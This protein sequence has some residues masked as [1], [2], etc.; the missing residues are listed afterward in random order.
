M[1][2]DMEKLLRCLEYLRKT[3][4]LVFSIKGDDYLNLMTYIDASYT[5]RI[6]TESHMVY[7]LKKQT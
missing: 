1:L 2:Q 6:K 4:N 7:L 3:K 5:E